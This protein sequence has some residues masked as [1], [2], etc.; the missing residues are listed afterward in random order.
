MRRM[1]FLL[2]LVAVVVNGLHGNPSL[3][4][5]VPEGSLE[6][7]E[8]QVRPLL[9]KRCYECH[10]GEKTKGGLALDSRAG[11]Q[12]GGDSG[13]VIVAGKPDES[14]LI[15]AINYRSV[16]MP[17]KEKG[18]KLSE[19]EIAVLTQWVRLG[20]PD[21]REQIAKLGGMA[22]S[23]AKGWW[24]YQPL[25][26][27]AAH[28]S[29]VE[30][31]AFLQKRLAEHGLSSNPAANKRTLIRR[32][33]YDLTGLPPTPEEVDAF[34][35]D[36][37]ADAFAKLIERLL[38]SPEYGVKWGRHWLDV[39][40]YADTAGENTDRPLPH[41]WRYRNWV[42][43]AFN[44]D[45]PFDEFARLQLAG[46]VLRA[47]G[48]GDEARE[49]VIATGYLA[50]AR[51]FGHDI[52][53]DIHL[54]HEDVIDNV[55][56]NFLGLTIGCARCH[57]HKYDPITAADYYALYGI[58][59]SSRFSFP[60]CEPKGQPRDLVPLLS[61][62]EV[63]S[64][65]APWRDRVAKVEQEKKRRIE[66]V[67]PTARLKELAA[68][69]VR[70][71]AAAKVNEGADV[72]ILDENGR[73]LDRVTAHK[74]DVFQLTIFPND[75]HGADTTLID[76][77]IRE[78]GGAG[79]Q[80]SLAD[81]VSSL[82]QGNP[83]S[84]VADAAW[85]FVE[86]TDGPV[87]LNQKREEIQGQSALKSWSISDLPSVFVNS[88]DQPVTVWSTLP[89]KS[90]FVHPGPARPVAVAWVCPVDG[91]FSLSGHVVDAHPGALD[92]VSYQLDQFSSPEFGAAL[93]EAGRILAAP[94]PD[95]G[96]AP[97][98]PVAYGV[99]EAEAKNV[100]I[101]QRGEPELPGDEVPRR[102]L[103]IFGGES[104]AADAGSGRVALGNWI[105]TNPLT[106]R[107]M[108]NR[109]W[110]GH[111]GRG[112][113]RSPNDFGA[114]G[115]RPSHPELLD[116]LASQFVASGYHV[117][118]MH[119][120]IMNSA[121]Y[122]QNSARSEIALEKDPENRLLGRFERRRLTAE[123][124]RDS[125]L[126]MSGTLDTRPGEAHPF[127]PESTWTFSQHNPFNAVYDTN[128]RS[129]YLM[130]QRQ[131]RH[132]YLTL[133]DGADTNSSTAIRQVTTV[134][135][136]ALYFMNDPFFHAQA[137]MLAETLLKLPDDEARVTF[138]YRKLF[139][140]EPAVAERQQA[141]GFLNV[142]P[143]TDDE[144]WSALAR[145]LLAGN[146]FVYVD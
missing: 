105:A 67:V 73:P 108:V 53:K 69:S 140:R 131:R 55:G 58:F 31:D 42:F 106:A 50:V 89:A 139:Q 127:P 3:S 41:A 72:P 102:W 101:H 61:P 120:L 134:P 143:G 45:L 135:T 85:C 51:R 133:F 40:R 76:W 26:I 97:T 99:V 63:E 87:F 78:I 122:Q 110:Q 126:L 39:V 80:W 32:A 48:T 21:P 18:G 37:S 111:F 19:A 6:F 20:A 11:W 107:V 117:K 25:P 8:K 145:V 4:Q 128:Q 130:V 93:A 113:V 24:S 100:R 94:L 57:D 54:M 14:P 82:T 86:V 146:E 83:R 44:R 116:W 124:I 65:M 81:L 23:D 74:N 7:F 75:N 92:G 91:E 12:K 22:V 70:R 121:A 138:A 66:A 77:T 2:G 34:V 119:R 144:K 115:E 132:P 104:V 68:Q 112:L 56:K 123:E 64:Q 5:D 38:A 47:K 60:G 13:P 109:I 35:V 90:F 103:S 129:A 36:T 142:Y 62:S 17:P 46:D 49:G 29:P 28:G 136:Q 98:I 15:D 96:P 71:L 95:P 137:K 1:S 10:S 114:R 59:N 52:D 27:A 9:V 16:E 33:T 118:S 88:S 125:L 30:I 43:E 141:A 84:G 79:H